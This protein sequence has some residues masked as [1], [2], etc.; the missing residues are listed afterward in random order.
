MASKWSKKVDFIVCDS[1]AD[2]M[3][4]M[5]DFAMPVMCCLHF[6]CKMLSTFD[7]VSCAHQLNAGSRLQFVFGK[8][9]DA[10]VG[11]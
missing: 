4:L 3:M 1:V 11:E 8:I 9:D 10:S 2:P 7:H 6:V 5:L